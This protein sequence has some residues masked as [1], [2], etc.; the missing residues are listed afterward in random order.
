M[1]MKEPFYLGLLILK[2]SKIV[3]HEFRI[4]YVEFKYGEN[5]KICYME[6]DI[7]ILYIKIEGVWERFYTSNY[8]FDRPVPKKT[9]AHEAKK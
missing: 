3:M 1:L 6:T 5:L 9:N 8:D 2:K 7:F 4:D